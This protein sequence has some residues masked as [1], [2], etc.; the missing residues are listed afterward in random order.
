MLSAFIRYGQ[1]KIHYL[2]HGSGSNNIICLHGYGES[3][4][5]FNSIV[6]H[7]PAAFSLIAID[8]PFHGQTEWNENKPFTIADISAV[9][10]QI[11]ETHR[12]IQ[13]SFVLVGY[14]M[15]GR[16]ALS[17]LQHCPEKISRLI[18]LAPDG[19]K[20][21]FWYWLSTQTTMGNRLFRYILNNPK[22]LL[23]TINISGHFKLINKSVFKFISK[24]INDKKVCDQ[25]FNR[26]TCM[27]TFKPG[28]KKV[29]EIIRV[30][31]I[32]VKM[33]YGQHDRIIV[34]RRA[35]RIRK[36]LE[37]LC[38]LYIIDAGHQVL[39]PRYAGIITSLIII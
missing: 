18:L 25:L 30:K 10:T 36:G 34:T 27:R 7:L 1:S 12:I 21:N 6:N 11:F 29:R 2:Y 20:V 38:E 9:L 24:Y 32:S 37:S 5:S 33:L 22:L 23:K 28:I 17:L 31:K 3:A 39:Q 4:A 19:L 16:I 13:Q 14:S 8:L 15:G 26:W 35:A